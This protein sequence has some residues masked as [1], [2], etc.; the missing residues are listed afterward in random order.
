MNPDTLRA[1]LQSVTSVF[2]GGGLLAGVRYILPKVRRAELR[3]LDTTNDATA[4]NSANAYIVSLQAGQKTSNDDIIILKN[5]LKELRLSSE[6]ALTAASNQI[7]RLSSE[8]ARVRADLVVAN[9]TISQLGEYMPG[10]HSTN[11]YHG[12]GEQGLLNGP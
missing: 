10:R 12:L 9:A 7:E 2:L 4:L 1:I 11:P 3:K 6:S 8:L 5:E